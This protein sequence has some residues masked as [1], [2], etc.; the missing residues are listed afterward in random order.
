MTVNLLASIWYGFQ[1]RLHGWL[2]IIVAFSSL[3]QG[4]VGVWCIHSGLV[5]G[6]VSFLHFHLSYPAS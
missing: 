1:S 2:P 4:W 3:R 5:A 6:Y